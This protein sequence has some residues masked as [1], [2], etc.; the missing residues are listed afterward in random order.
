MK[1]AVSIVVLVAAVNLVLAAPP[2]P[3][4]GPPPSPPHKYRPSNGAPIPVKYPHPGHFGKNEY[5]S[6]YNPHQLPPGLRG[7]PPPFTKFPQSSQQQ[8]SNK[9][10]LPSNYKLGP[11]FQSKPYLIP[12]GPPKGL[13]ASASSSVQSRPSPKI[14]NVW[15][16]PPKFGPEFPPAKFGSEQ[17]SKFGSE[18]PPKFGPEFPPKFG[19]EFPSKFGPEFPP[20]K[21]APEFP[22]R[23]FPASPAAP[24]SLPEKPKSS[25]IINSDDE[26]GPIKTIP[27]PNLNPAD[28]P[29]NFEEQLYR[30]QHAPQ[31]YVQPLDNS[32]SD[33]KYQH[34]IHVNI[35]AQYL[36]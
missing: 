2:P 1:V 32:I 17:P 22:I 28:K 5:Y 15:S 6:K 10:P 23:G 35:A 33:E 21:F 31:Q 13:Q 20:A 16:G 11:Q 3:G 27:A 29:A 24:A 19:P 8:P 25:Y 34:Q 36:L 14:T 9:Q 30:A 18:L 7:P 12:S 26:R 4:F